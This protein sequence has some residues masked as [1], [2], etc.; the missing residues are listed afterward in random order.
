[1][2]YRVLFVCTGNICRSPTAEAVFRAR[3]AAAGLEVE[4]DSAGT[5]DWHVGAAPDARATAAAARRGLDLSTQTARQVRLNDFT[6]FDLLVAMDRGHARTLE[7]RRPAGNGAKV[8][9]FLDFAPEL[10]IRDVPDPYFGGPDGFER[11]LD[12]IERA[13]D[14]LVEAIR[15]KAV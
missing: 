14:R 8:R 11:V 12:M 9:L 6:R 2:A 3:A 1:M 10:T 15:A 5:G 13:S 7:R 4:A